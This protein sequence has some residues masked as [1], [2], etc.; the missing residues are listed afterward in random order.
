M[1]P[2]TCDHQVVL[3]RQWRQRVCGDLFLRQNTRSATTLMLA[4]GQGKG[5]KAHLWSSFFLQRLSMALDRGFSL[6]HAINQLTREDERHGN[7]PQ[8]SFHIIRILAD[9][10]T[11]LISR[12]MPPTLCW[13]HHHQ[14][15]AP[16]PQ[17]PLSDHPK[18]REGFLVLEPGDRL[19]CCSDGVAQAHK[20]KA[21]PEGWGMDGV[22]TFLQDTASG[23]PSAR[24]LIA[25]LYQTSHGKLG[26]DTSC[27][28]LCARTRNDLHIWLGPPPPPEIRNHQDTF[29]N[30]TGRKAIVGREAADAWAHRLGLKPYLSPDKRYSLPGVDL[31]LR[32]QDLLERYDA[33][34]AEDPQL[35]TLT[36][37]I[38]SADT[39]GLHMGKPLK[40]AEEALVL[41][42]TNTW[43]EEGKTWWKNA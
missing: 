12:S 40:K 9:G 25:H 18:L 39:I 2:I 38:Q 30:Q 5:M 28:D 20:D 21:H 15:P 24:T 17:T 29:W 27:L 42:L 32:R 3:A 6:R 43:K 14:A 37:W 11:T 1:N 13:P 8:T 7:D 16:L 35:N 41:R 4:D 34:P 26:D 23:F 10:R 33:R 19:L 22:N 36:Q 31:V